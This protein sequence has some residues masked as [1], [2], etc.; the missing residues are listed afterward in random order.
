MNTTPQLLYIFFS[1]VTF[2]SLQEFAGDGLRT[3]ALAYKDLDEDYFD[4]WMKKLLFASTVTENREEQL[5]VLYEEIE[6]GLKV[7]LTSSVYILEA[8]KLI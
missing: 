5:A 6:W 4:V 2:L 8:I 3:L 1:V 7:K